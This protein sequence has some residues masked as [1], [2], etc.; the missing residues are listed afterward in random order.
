MQVVLA[1]SV[2][3]YHELIYPPGSPAVLTFHGPQLAGS[4]REVQG[5]MAAVMVGCGVLYT[6]KPHSG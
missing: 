1:G 5:K 4:G 6:G 2:Y 3:L